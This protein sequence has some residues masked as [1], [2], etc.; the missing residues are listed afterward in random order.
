[1]PFKSKS[2]LRLCY[3]KHDKNWNCDE[4]LEKTKNV[5]CL[6]EKLAYG[7]PKCRPIRKGERVK[8]KIQTGPRGGKFFFIT[9]K[10]KGKTVCQVKVYLT[11]KK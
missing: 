2:Q 5:C 8:G 6:P 7:K 1:M 11:R 10:N 3:N 4:F 9:E